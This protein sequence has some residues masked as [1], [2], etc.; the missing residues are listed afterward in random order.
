[1]DYQEDD[2]D[3]FDMPSPQGLPIVSNGNRNM[4]HNVPNIGL[5]QNTSSAVDAL[6]CFN[7]RA[8]IERENSNEEEVMMQ[9]YPHPNGYD[10]SQETNLSNNDGK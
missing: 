9:S 10:S 7:D 5:T 8:F 1:M 4:L 3:V 2:E 6:L